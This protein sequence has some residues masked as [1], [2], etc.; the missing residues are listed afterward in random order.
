MK[1]AG[2]EPGDA[3]GTVVKLDNS[4]PLDNAGFH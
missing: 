2:P 3:P 4:R 1:E